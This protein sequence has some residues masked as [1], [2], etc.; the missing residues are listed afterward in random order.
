MH[1]AVVHLLVAFS[2]R[3]LR[4]GMARESWVVLPAP[5]WIL[6]PSLKPIRNQNR[7]S[8]A[9]KT[10]KQKQNQLGEGKL[11]EQRGKV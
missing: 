10:N 2:E 4:Q 1:L 6:N 5:V 3:G 9:R 7:S 11:K 8:S